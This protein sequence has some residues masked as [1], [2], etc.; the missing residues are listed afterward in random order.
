MKKAKN[1]SILD[2]DPNI[3]HLTIEFSNPTK[4]ARVKDMT[5]DDFEIQ[6]ID[7]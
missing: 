5:S 3:G 4:E 7:L 6:S 2:R 1:L